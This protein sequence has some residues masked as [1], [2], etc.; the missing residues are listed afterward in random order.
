MSAQGACGTGEGEAG[1]TD[2]TGGDVAKVC[3]YLVS[4]S[5]F[6]KSVCST[7][8]FATLFVIATEFAFYKWLNR[9]RD[10]PSEDE[11]ETSESPEAKVARYNR[12]GMSE[13]SDPD[14]W[15]EVR[16]FD[17][18]PLAHD[19]ADVCDLDDFG[20]LNPNFEDWH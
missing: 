5:S 20:R 12:C 15:M 13:V 9:D 14:F 18:D 7:M 19:E 10:R 16:H 1:G 3:F 11:S 8:F 6:L 4:I 2:G 17:E